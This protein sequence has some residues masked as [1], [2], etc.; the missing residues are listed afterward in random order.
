M[1]RSS[2]LSAAVVL[3]RARLQT[4]IGPPGDLCSG[5][6][7]SNN[8]RTTGRCSQVKPQQRKCPGHCRKHPSTPVELLPGLTILHQTP[9]RRKAFQRWQN[10][11]CTH[12]ALRFF[13][14]Q[15]EPALLLSPFSLLP[16]DSNLLATTVFGLDS[17][18][19]RT[20]SMWPFALVFA[21][22]VCQN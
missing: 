9:G 2:S 22:L 8:L 14:Y 18:D 19:Q 3:L 15:Q 12:A 13:R 7:P 5:G 1:S 10:S 16:T 11:C 17:L 21:S 20:A 4:V 6:G